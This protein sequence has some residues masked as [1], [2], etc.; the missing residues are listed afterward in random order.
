MHL[1]IVPYTRN[2]AALVLLFFVV[3]VLNNYALNFN[4]SMPLHMIFRS[5]GGDGLVSRTKE[6]EY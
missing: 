5:V 2:Y 1:M 6:L 3:S 4:I